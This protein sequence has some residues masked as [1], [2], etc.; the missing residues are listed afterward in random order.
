VDN[1]HLKSPAEAGTGVLPPRTPAGA[2]LRLS[3]VGG[4]TLKAH[5]HKYGD[6]IT[7]NG[8]PA[9]EVSGCAAAP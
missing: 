2:L 6:V 4:T 9:A 7:M 1:L 5:L 8:E 3:A